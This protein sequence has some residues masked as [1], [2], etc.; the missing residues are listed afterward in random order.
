MSET[1]L[2]NVALE[3]RKRGKM[4]ET[5]SFALMSTFCLGLF[6][7]RAYRTDGLHFAFLIWNLFLAFIP[8]M[9]S[10]A[11]LLWKGLRKTKVI[12]IPLLLIWVLFFPNAPY[13]LTDLFHLSNRSSMPMWFDLILILSF[14]W[15]GLLFGFASMR[16][17][18]VLCAGR[19]QKWTINSLIAGFLFLSSFGIYIGRY[20]R[21]NSWDIVSRPQELMGD[22]LAILTQP[23]AHQKAWGMTLLLGTMLN[24][25][26][27]TIRPGGKQ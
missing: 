4:R 1:I 24:V 9:I 6:V 3:D 2:T 11:M 16:D 17:I 5:L 15:T 22:L 21:W 23:M 20:L 18:A 19:L 8:W 14:A 27:W 10:S 26:Y 7:L 13:I 25:I 12:A